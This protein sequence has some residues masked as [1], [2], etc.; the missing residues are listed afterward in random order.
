LIHR[1]HKGLKKT[2]CW[3]STFKIN[4]LEVRMRLGVDVLFIIHSCAAFSAP[5]S[6]Y[7]Q[8]RPQIVPSFLSEKKKLMPSN[9]CFPSSESS[10]QLS[11]I[12]HNDAQNRTISDSQIIYPTLG[13]FVIA[14]VELNVPNAQKGNSLDGGWFFPAIFRQPGRTRQRKKE[15]TMRPAAG[16]G[17]VFGFLVGGPFGALV[18]AAASASAV[19]RQDTVGDAARTASKA[20]GLAWDMSAK[21]LE[22]VNDSPVGDVLRVS[23]RNAEKIVD[24]IATP[25]GYSGN[26]KGKN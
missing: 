24:S 2:F 1:H 15:G 4:S 21:A 19:R 23:V 17:A 18:G 13:R 14:D 22:T 5:Y 16:I 8:T 12:H 20:A 6:T 10:L 26:G 11:A 9:C 3:K 7:P 25:D